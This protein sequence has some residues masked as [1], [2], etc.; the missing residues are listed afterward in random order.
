MFRFCF[1]PIIESKTLERVFADIVNAPRPRPIPSH[2]NK[3]ICAR[4][5]EGDERQTAPLKPLLCFPFFYCLFEYFPV[6]LS[7]LIF[8]AKMIHD[9]AVLTHCEEC[10]IC[11]PRGYPWWPS[12]PST[13]CKPGLNI[14]FQGWWEI[15]PANEL[16]MPDDKGV[17]WTEKAA[18]MRRV[19]CF[20]QDHLKTQG[21]GRAPAE[22]VPAH[23]ILATEDP[24]VGNGA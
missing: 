15:G 14:I 20:V 18:K 10:T 19:P 16:G 21:D 12:P 11:S 7:I 8:F 13:G 6:H 17:I 5:I 23:G 3:L 22:G 9:V 4:W 1:C 24:R 2:C